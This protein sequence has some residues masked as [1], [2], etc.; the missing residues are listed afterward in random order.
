MSESQ[1][2]SVVIASYNHA[3]FIEECLRSV[4]SQTYDN[5]ELVVIDDCSV[6]TTFS[7]VKRVTG[8]RCFRSRFQKITSLRSKNNMG[9][10]ATF[11]AGARIAS[12]NYITFLNSDDLYEPE[13]LAV[14]LSSA[15]AAPNS[16]V[17]SDVKFI[18]DNGVASAN[19][20]ALRL[21]ASFSMIDSLPSLSFAFLRHQITISTGNLFMSSRLVSKD[22]F[23]QGFA[24]LSRLGLRAQA[25]GRERADSRHGYIVPI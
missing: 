12:G 24:I 19:Q 11:N 3:G 10:H 9:A 22:W 17:F 4:Y 2:V 13:R 21:G 7:I 25:G 23:L 8:A 14:L 20:I 15:E 1:T 5:I 18:D 6:D 16:M